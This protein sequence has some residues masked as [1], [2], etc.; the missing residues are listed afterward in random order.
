MIGGRTRGAF[1]WTLIGLVLLCG[2][3]R[4]IWVQWRLERVFARSDASGLTSPLIPFPDG[5]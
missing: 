5:L 1:R 4:Y 2:G 3:D